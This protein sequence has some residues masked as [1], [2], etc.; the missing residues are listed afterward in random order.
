MGKTTLV[1]QREGGKKPLER[2]EASEDI[3]HLIHLGANL[4]YLR[5]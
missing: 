4:S 3:A 5:V 1:T 2:R